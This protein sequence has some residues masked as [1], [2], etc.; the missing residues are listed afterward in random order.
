M[1]TISLHFRRLIADLETWGRGCGK[2]G[3]AEA[4][5]HRACQGGAALVSVPFRPTFPLARHCHAAN[6]WVPVPGQGLP[7][8]PD[9]GR[10]SAPGVKI[11]FQSQYTPGPRS[12]HSP[13]SGRHG[14]KGSHPASW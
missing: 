5:A 9:L 12:H 4:C 11:V 1:A 10:T 3:L 8:F 7:A 2:E 14:P 6:G 13:G